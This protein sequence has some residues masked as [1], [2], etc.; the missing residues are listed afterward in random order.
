MKRAAVVRAAALA[1]AAGAGAAVALTACAGDTPADL[2]TPEQYATQLFDGVNAEREAAGLAPLEW[3]DCLATKAAPRAEQAATTPT[4][5][6]EP[7]TS[8]CLDAVA[9]GENLSRGEFTAQEIVDQWMD[10]AGHAA[11]IERE[12]FTIAGAACA[13]LPDSEPGFACSLLFEGGS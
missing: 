13:P 2:G 6:H 8:S 5:T 3:S 4:L 9:S 7:L 12:G 11:N 10:S 1:V